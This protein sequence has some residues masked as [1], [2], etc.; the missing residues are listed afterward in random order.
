MRRWMEEMREDVEA[1]K[2]MLNVRRTAGL[3]VEAAYAAEEMMEEVMEEVM[4][5]MEAGV[6]EAGAAAAVD[7]AGE[8]AVTF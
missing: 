2:G 7:D 5:V 6:A 8:A 3:A 4:E 1:E